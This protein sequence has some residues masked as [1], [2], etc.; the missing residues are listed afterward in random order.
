M[1]TNIH[2]QIRSPFFYLFF[3]LP[4]MCLDVCGLWTSV[5]KAAPHCQ[6]KGLG[7]K[8][9]HSQHHW[10]GA[11]SLLMTAFN[12]C[13][14]PVS[15]SQSVFVCS[16]KT[17][18]VCAS[19]P[20]CSQRERERKREWFGISLS[21]RGCLLCHLHIGSSGD[22]AFTFPL[23]ISL[24]LN[25]PQ[26]TI[27]H[28]EAQTLRPRTGFGRYLQET[29]FLFFIKDLERLHMCAEFHKPRSKQQPELTVWNLLEGA[30][31]TFRH[32]RKDFTRMFPVVVVGL[33]SS[34]VRCRADS[35]TQCLLLD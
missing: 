29:F 8:A 25:R 17:G 21:L 11:S 27:S 19:L 26:T 10:A 4:W 20:V 6:V 15:S 1:L 18:S 13:R 35:M 7:I 16:S 31:D 33:M 5:K 14:G 9:L 30:V 22:R 23:S 34:Y 2:E 3:F 28:E 32:S 12:L 24:S